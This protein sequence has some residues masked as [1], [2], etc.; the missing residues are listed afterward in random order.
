MRVTILSVRQVLRIAKTPFEQLATGAKAAAIAGWF[1][2][3]RSV[4]AGQQVKLDSCLQRRPI[5]SAGQ[6]AGIT[7]ETLR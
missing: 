4:W 6:S 7:P 1:T 2:P 5:A 3:K